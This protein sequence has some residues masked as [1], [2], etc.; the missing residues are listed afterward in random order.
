MEKDIRYTDHGWLDMSNLTYKGTLIDWKNSIGASIP[1]QYKHIQ[2]EV[3]VKEHLNR[4]QIVV[5]IAGIVKDVTIGI[6]VLYRGAFG[7]LLGFKNINFKYAIGEVVHENILII[8]S[9]K[10]KRP[11]GKQDKMYQCKCLIDN[12]EWVIS[13]ANLKNNRGCPVCHGNVI[14]KGIN[15]IATTM[16]DIAVLFT[17][18]NDRYIY[19]KGMRKKVSVTCPKC[20]K[21]QSKVIADICRHGFSCE[22]CND[23]VSYPEKVM[24]LLLREIL[25]ESEIKYQHTFDWSKNIKTSFAPN[26]KDMRYDFYLPNYSCIIETHGIQHYEETN[27]S[28]MGELKH[29]QENDLVK[30][31]IAL[32]NGIAH[33]IEIDCRFSNIEYIKKS[34]MESVL[35]VILDFTESNIDWLDINKTALSSSILMDVVNYWNNG[36][37]NCTTIGRIIKLHQTTI[38]AY[39]RKANSLNLLTTP[40]PLP[41][42][43]PKQSKSS[44]SAS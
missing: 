40:Y 6:H 30:K 18:E 11:N 43:T 14:V 1:F 38:S 12:H 22:Y 23:G 7:Y 17:N 24:H 4:R 35:P 5:D 13:E 9:F 28:Y 31:D 34:I 41:K 15:D 26:G 42:S 16:P 37:Y 27:M 32:K 2:G 36:L 44:L 39:L 19:S 33:Y 29:I 25:K 8:S 20:G 3:I 21:I 10:Q